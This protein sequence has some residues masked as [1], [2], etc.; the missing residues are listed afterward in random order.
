MAYMGGLKAMNDAALSAEA[1]RQRSTV[2]GDR[3]GDMAR[4]KAAV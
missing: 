4:V 1:K 3:E 2:R